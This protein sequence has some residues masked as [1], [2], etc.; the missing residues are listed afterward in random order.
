MR[1]LI[2]AAVMGAAVWGGVAQAGDQPVVVELFTSQGCASCPPADA[3]LGELAGRED[4]IALGLHVDYWDYIGWKDVFGSPAFTKRQKDY[5]KAA[6]RRTMYTPQLIVGGKDHVV[7]FRPMELAQLIEMHHAV[8]DRV[9]LTAVR[10]GGDVVLRARLVDG[11]TV[12]M[13]VQLARFSRKET[14]EIENGENAGRTITYHNV[15]RDWSTLGAWDGATPLT[16]EFAAP[17]GPLAIII[18]EAGYGPVV[19]AARLD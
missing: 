19:A 14:V 6:G 11:P 4:V 13:V 8:P 15:V 2:A 5:A 3:L 16:L 17:D 18:Q 12:N 9:N 7:G 1:R 10:Q